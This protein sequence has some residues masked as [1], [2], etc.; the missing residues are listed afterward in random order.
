MSLLDRLLESHTVARIW[1][2]DSTVFAPASAGTALHNAIAQRFGWLDAPAAM[3][4]HLPALHD[5]AD[6]A[7]HDGLTDIYLLGMGGSSLCAEVLRDTA[8]LSATPRLTV[9]DTTDELAVDNAAAELTAAR[10]LF[11]VASKSGTTVEVSSLERYFGSLMAR[12]VGDAAGAHFV[13]ITDPDTPLVSHAAERA[14]RH[15][16]V[17]P[18]DIGGRYSALSLFGLVPAALLGLDLEQLLEGAR[19]MA[20]RCQFEQADNP[21]LALGAFMAEQ[22]A[23]KR[24]KLTVFLPAR[25]APLG[26]WIEQLVAESTG[27]EGRGILPVV[28]EPAGMVKEYA[29]DRAF[30]LVDDAEQSGAVAQLGAELERA[31]HAIFRVSTDPGGLGAEFFR[32]EFATAVAG[33]GLGINPFDEPNVREAKMRTHS[34]LDAFRAT[35]ALRVDPPVKPVDGIAGCLIRDNRAARNGGTNGRYFATLDYLPLDRTRTSAITGLRRRVRTATQMATTYGI[36]PRY[37]H[38]TGQYH[39]GGPNTGLFVLLTAPD[40][41]T[42]AVPGTDYSFSVLKQAQALGDF[43]ALAAAGRDV[44][45]FHFDDPSIDV[46]A[47]VEHVLRQRGWIS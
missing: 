22:A 13:A 8:S 9:L 47:A 7:R 27:K 35:G 44:V 16:F 32:W 28:D 42:T 24:D 11:V 18:P 2:R 38:S 45:H 6:R 25:L 4:A 30:V 15:T 36:G 43:D 29:S 41:M 14:Y 17:N 40:A 5:F 23:A 19:S 34:L 1:R 31:G 3:A 39:K 10:A 37:L 12:A 33:A 20:A 26:A 46:A 21:G